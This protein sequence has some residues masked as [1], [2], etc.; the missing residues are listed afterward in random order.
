PRVPPNTPAKE[1][2]IWWRNDYFI[3]KESALGGLGAFAAIDLDEGATILEELPLLRTNIWDVH[4]QFESLNDE[5]RELLFSLHKYHPNPE[6]HVFDKIRKAN[7]F[8]VTDGVTMYSVTSRFNHAC[9]PV[10]NVSY[11]IDERRGG[12]ITLT[13][14]QDV[15]KGTELTICYGGTPESLLKNFGFRCQ[16]G[17]CTPLTDEEVEKM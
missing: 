5:D 10:R 9:L 13:M 1:D 17:G 15:A 7:S 2:C 3:I 14:L 8:R 11:E 4:N 12:K 6:A 16:C